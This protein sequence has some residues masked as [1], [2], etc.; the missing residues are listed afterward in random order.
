VPHLCGLVS[1]QPVTAVYQLTPVVCLV[2]EF[3]RGYEP[4]ARDLAIQLSLNAR[5][6]FVVCYPDGRNLRYLDGAAA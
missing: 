2:A 3:Q 4:T 6:L 5:R 1:D